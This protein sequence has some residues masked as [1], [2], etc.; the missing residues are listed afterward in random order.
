MIPFVDDEVPFEGFL[1]PLGRFFFFFVTGLLVDPGAFVVV[2]VVLEVGLSVM[3]FRCFRMASSSSKLPLKLCTI[4][5]TSIFILS[6]SV[7]PAKLSFSILVMFVI[8]VESVRFR[9]GFRTGGKLLTSSG[10]VYNSFFIV[11]ASSGCAMYICPGWELGGI[12]FL[13]G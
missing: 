11:D 2:V 5:L 12:L 10:V 4:L 8:M 6:S 7:M 1:L 13:V 3:F 9:L